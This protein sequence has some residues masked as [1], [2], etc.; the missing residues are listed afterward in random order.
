LF[1][2]PVTYVVPL[3]QRPYVWTKGEHWQPLWE[4]FLAVAE[5]LLDARANA[6]EEELERGVPE[7]VTPS[8]FLGAVVLE[9]VPTGAGMIE[10]RN[11]IDG[12][13]RLLTLQLFLDAAHDVA[14]EYEDERARLF[15]MLTDNDPHLVQAQM[16]HFKVWPTNVDRVAFQRT[17]GENGDGEGEE[18]DVSA[19][20]MWMAHDYFC[21]ALREW[22]ESD[23]HVPVADRLDVLRVVMWSLVRLVVID[24][25]GSD[26]AQVIFETLNARGTPLLASDLIKNSLFQQATLQHLKIEDLYESRWKPLDDDWWR[27]KVPQGRLFRPRL[28]VFFFHW[29][30]MRR[31]ADFGVHELFTQYKNYAE[32][33]GDPEATLKDIV[34]HAKTYRSFESYP[35]N[36]PE[37]TFFY[38]LKVTE[39]ATATPLLLLTMGQPD[40]VVPP[41]QKALL[42]RS[43][44]SWLI[45]RML[46]RLTTKN[47]NVV[48]LNLLAAILKEPEAAGDIAVAY[49]S[50]LQGESQVWPSDAMVEEALLTLPLYRIVGR[51]RLRMALEALEDAM[52]PEGLAEES[53]GPRQLTIEHVLPQSWQEHWPLPDGVNPV[54]AATTRD[55]LKHSIGNLTLVT[56][57]LNPAMSNAAWATKRGALNEFTTLYLNKGLV[58]D[59]ADRWDEDT[60]RERG[61][62]LAAQAVQVWPAPDAFDVDGLVLAAIASRVA[63]AADETSASAPLD[64]GE[65][66]EGNGNSFS[67]ETI[68]ARSKT[69]FVRGAVDGIDDW[70]ATQDVRVQHNKRSNHSMYAG[71]RWIGS[72]YFA[73]GWVH[74]W[75]VRRDPSDA[76]FEELSQPASLLLKNNGVAGNLLNEADLDMFK[77]GVQAR[78]G[79]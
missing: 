74:F 72:F 39:T 18:V 63:E 22:L 42:M 29:L 55:T 78:I 14:A 8:H 46:C 65:A 4:D 59:Y 20:S 12:Q 36:S 47:Y 1:N 5:R 26:N 66:P 41:A 71:K 49:F 24:L 38:R 19:T 16:D 57:K 69:D 28:D 32:E 23:Q 33:V 58:N 75:L 10:R 73:R 37:E 21:E 17:L 15:G 40:D 54:E 61:K 30:T 52:R 64:E 27:V 60:I 70:L 2:R 53:H 11:I 44:E 67:H 25:E 45:R 35:A 50:R 6:T 43:L 76:N 51:G 34:H 77:I 9:Q 79:T 13:Q 62:A 3:F 31:G 48:F 68:R 7:Q 56:H